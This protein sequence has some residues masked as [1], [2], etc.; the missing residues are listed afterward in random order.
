MSNYH[1]LE[2]Q[3]NGNRIWVVFHLPV[4]DANNDASMNYQDIMAAQLGAGWT[5]RVPHITAGEVT[6]IEAGELIEHPFEYL[7]N[8]TIPL[9]T[10]RDELDAKFATLSTAAAARITAQYQYYGIDRDVT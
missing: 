2:G 4:A 3:E 8:P 7:T 10:K 5:S 6:Q 1:I 9:A